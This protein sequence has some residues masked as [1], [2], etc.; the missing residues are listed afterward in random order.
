MMTR[1]KIGKLDSPKYLR[2]D[3]TM[4]LLLT[5]DDP[6]EGRIVVHRVEETF[7]R[8]LVVTHWVLFQVPG[9]DTV[10]GMFGGPELV[11]AVDRIFCHAVLIPDSEPLIPERRDKPCP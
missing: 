5:E 11:D 8:S 4:T 9:A 7:H 10:G 3:S 1:Y 2:P 6:N